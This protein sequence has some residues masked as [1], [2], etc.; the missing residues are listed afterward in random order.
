MDSG[1]STCAQWV[2]GGLNVGVSLDSDVNNCF[3][4]HFRIAGVAMRARMARTGRQND[5]HTLQL[6][7]LEGGVH[8][9]TGYSAA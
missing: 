3:A 5:V 2:G 4:Q 1:G 8:P 6:Q 9:G 7:V